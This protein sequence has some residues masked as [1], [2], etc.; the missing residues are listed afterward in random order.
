MYFGDGFTD[1]RGDGVITRLQGVPTTPGTFTYTILAENEWGRDTRTFTTT[2]STRDDLDLPRFITTSL[3]DGR[4]GAAYNDAV[5]AGG[6]QPIP[7]VVG[8]TPPAWYIFS[9]RLPNG[10]SLDVNTGAIRGTPTVAGTFTFVVSIAHNTGAVSS[11]S[12]SREFTITI[13][14]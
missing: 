2:V 9:G 5:L 6:V 12:I 3:P 14:P 4:V 8:A 1:G 10:L 13:R 7:G 11:G